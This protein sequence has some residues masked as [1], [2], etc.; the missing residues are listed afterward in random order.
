MLGS[1]KPRHLKPLVQLHMFVESLGC[2]GQES[3]SAYQQSPAQLIGQ[4]KLHN[5]AR[6]DIAGPAE[7]SSAAP[8]SWFVGKGRGQV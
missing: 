7:L 2:R 3:G 6:K 5:N 4:L 8:V 1:G